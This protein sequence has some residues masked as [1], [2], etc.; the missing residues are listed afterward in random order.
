[1]LFP[2]QPGSTQ[3]IESAAAAARIDALLRLEAIALAAL[4]FRACPFNR[5]KG[6][7]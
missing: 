2:H 3:S 1:M 7:K 5:V 6:I 4:R